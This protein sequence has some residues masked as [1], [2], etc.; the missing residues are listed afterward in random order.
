MKA[1]LT[2]CLTLGL[3]LMAASAPQANAGGDY[4][5]GAGS[6]KDYGGTPVPAPI[7]VPLY[8]PVWYFRGDVGIG[9]AESLGASQSGMVFGEAANRYQAGHVFGA[10]SMES[11]F[12]DTVVFGVGVGYRFSDQV[13]LDLTGES[14]RDQTHRLVNKV[15]VPVL[16]RGH[17]IPGYVEADSN[18]RTTTR[19]GA[20]M[21]NAYY[22]LPTHWGGFTPYV[23]AGLGFALLGVDRNSDIVERVRDNNPPRPGTTSTQYHSQQSSTDNIMSLAASV[24]AGTTY[25]ISD[26]TELDFNYRYLY[27]DGVDA[28]VDVNGHSSTVETDGAHDHQLRAGVRFNIQ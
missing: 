5:S 19:G 22:D 14:L 25:R 9:F 7:P 6:V 10:G 1:K 21:L 23:G 16:F 26:I 24:T 4:Y 15:R 17:S 27:V 11:D 12:D 18:D 28:T 20:I 8:D 13:R 2:T 3:A